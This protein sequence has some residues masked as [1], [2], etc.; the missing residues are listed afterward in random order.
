MVDRHGRL[1]VE[2]L[3]AK[4]RVELLDGVGHSAMVEDP[5]RTAALLEVFS[6]STQSGVNDD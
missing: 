4:A 6:T 3:A 1:R 2:P 5:T